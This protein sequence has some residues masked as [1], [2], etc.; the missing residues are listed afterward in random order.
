MCLAALYD[1]LVPSPVFHALKAFCKV[2]VAF[3]T[4]SFHQVSQ[5]HRWGR[6]MPH[7]STVVLSRPVL[8]LFQISSVVVSATLKCKL[9]TSWKWLLIWGSLI[10]QTWRRG[11]KLR[12]DLVAHQSSCAYKKLIL[13]GYFLTRDHFHVCDRF[14]HGLRKRSPSVWLRFLTCMWW[15]GC[16]VSWNVFPRSRSNAR[17]YSRVLSPS[18]SGF[19]LPYLIQTCT[20]LYLVPA[21]PMWPFQYLL[22]IRKLDPGSHGTQLVKEQILNLIT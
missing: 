11:V 3:S 1:A 13:Q 14:A 10:F 7:T 6:V 9:R 8:M 4:C 22:G 19:S 5:C 2:A 18:T 12:L 15:D 17:V 21:L 16:H 20:S